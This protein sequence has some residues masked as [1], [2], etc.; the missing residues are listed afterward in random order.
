MVGIKKTS[1]IK[2]KFFDNKPSAK[3][4]EKIPLEDVDLD[5]EIE[6]EKEDIWD[7][8]MKFEEET[9]TVQEMDVD[10]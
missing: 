8:E 6:E 3:I 7:F 4:D 1:I 10:E 2:N 5:M 9:I